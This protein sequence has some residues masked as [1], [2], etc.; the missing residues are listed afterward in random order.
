MRRVGALLVY[1]VRFEWGL[2]VALTRWLLRRP[3]IPPDTTAWGYSRLVTPV[4]WLWILASAAEL[5]A[6]HLITPWPTVRLVLLVVSLWGLVWMVGLLASYRVYPHLTTDTHLRV[7]LGRHADLSV[8]WEDV[9]RVGVVDRDLAS[10]I[11]TFQPVDGPHGTDL[12][13][14]VSG[15][16]NVTVV[17]KRA[18]PVRTSGETLTIGAVSFL[19][20]DPRRL[21]A[22]TRSLASS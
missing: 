11:R 1:A 10:S 2:Y 13:I 22:A 8:A 5:V 14:G 17:L 12:H 15:R 21:V 20:D 19:A 4:M 9:A 6:V 18:L 16:A 3:D 7:R